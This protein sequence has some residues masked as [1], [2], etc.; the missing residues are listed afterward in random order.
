MIKVEEN[1]SL[2]ALNTF[3]IDAKAKYLCRI[4][5]IDQLTE[6]I[7][8]PLYKKEQ[9]YILGGGSNILFTG[10]FNGLL[11]KVDLLGIQITEETDHFVKIKVAAGENWHEFVQKAMHNDWGGVENLSLIPGT[12]GAAPMQNI[13]AYGVEIQS[14]IENVEGIDLSSGH[15]R[16][17]SRDE[18]E[19]GYRESAFKRGLKRKYFISSVTLRL[20]KNSHRLNT[21]Y[22]A[23][24]ETLNEMGVTDV[25]IQKISEAVIKIRQSKLPDP[26]VVGNAGS[27]FKNPTISSSQYETL[28]QSH[29]TMPGY[30]VD[31]QNIKVPAGWLIEQCGWKGK[32]VKNIG[33]HPKQALVIVNYGG[34]SGAE[35]LALAKKIQASVSQ[36]FEINLTPEVNII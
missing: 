3:G 23:I 11:I 15:I 29:V 33:V 26:L 18:C 14:L 31:N 4:S 21:S 9:H 35:I 1:A 30:Q 32:T 34:G 7:N 27:F 5:E 28:L 8:S 19:F 36:K 13:G 12:M 16:V 20:T 17:F 6:L 2:K 24:K 10:Y 25:T 22:G